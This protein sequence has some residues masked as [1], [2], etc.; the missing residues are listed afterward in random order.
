MRLGLVWHQIILVEELIIGDH[1][2]GAGRFKLYLGFAPTTVSRE[3]W[4]GVW[5]VLTVV[6]VMMT[7]GTLVCGADC[8]MLGEGD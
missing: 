5:Y 1:E 6:S 8:H 4:L 7:L 3:T 2:I